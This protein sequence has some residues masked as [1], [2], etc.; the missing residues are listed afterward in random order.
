ME[1]TVLK[2]KLS[3]FRSKEGY[4]VGVSADVLQEL[5]RAWE[6]WTGRSKDFY[7]SIGVG[8]KQMAFLLGKAKKM[9]REG[10]FPAEEFKEVQLASGM[11]GAGGPCSGIE[12][13]LDGGKIIRFPGVEPLIDFLKKSA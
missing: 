3:T 5:L 1:N 12:L 13:Q 8:Q 7:R 6:G 2:K 4:L 11:G 9:A 10:G